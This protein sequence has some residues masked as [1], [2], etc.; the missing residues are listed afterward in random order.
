MTNTGC[1]VITRTVFLKLYGQAGI[2][3]LDKLSQRTHSLGTKTCHQLLPIRVG[4]LHLAFVIGRRDFDSP[5]MLLLM[6][7]TGSGCL[8]AERFAWS[9]TSLDAVVFFGAA[10]VFRFRLSS[11]P[12]TQA[13]NPLHRDQQTFSTNCSASCAFLS[14]VAPICF[15]CLRLRSI[16]FASSFI[17]SCIWCRASAKVRP[18]SARR[19]CKRVISS[20]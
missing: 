13:A 14:A 18:F 9:G 16:L 7:C 11:V 8:E 6:L 5:K 3:L 17:S 15:Q 2:T 19:S 20:N 4:D 1:L 12:S 10:G